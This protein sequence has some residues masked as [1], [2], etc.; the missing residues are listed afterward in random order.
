MADAVFETLTEQ[1]HAKHGSEV[2]EYA[3][4]QDQVSQGH[5]RATKDAHRI[6]KR[7]SIFTQFYKSQ[8]VDIK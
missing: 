5:Q 8:L 2:D 6:R 1:F 7:W 4:Q 3:E